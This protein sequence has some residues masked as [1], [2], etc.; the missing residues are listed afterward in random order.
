M[1]GP[2]GRRDDGRPF[3]RGGC[4]AGGRC[5]PAGAYAQVF[6]PAPRP[7]L[8]ARRVGTAALRVRSV[9]HSG[10]NP[11]ILRD[12]K[13]C[14]NSPDEAEMACGG[15]VIAGGKTPGVFQTVEAV[16]GVGVM[17]LVGDRHLWLGQ[18]GICQGVVAG[19][20]RDL[21]CTEGDSRAT[22]MGR[23]WPLAQGWIWSRSH[24]L[25]GRDPDCGSPL[26]PAAQWRARTIALSIICTLSGPASR[27]S[28]SLGTVSRTPAMRRWSG[29]R[30]P[31][32]RIAGGPVRET[33]IPP[34]TPASVPG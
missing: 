6:L 25:S 23:P 13:A 16:L 14:G 8:G 2:S 32:P 17:V 18:V 15:L 1:P 33:S 28:R 19:M 11:I 21:A 30:P 22:V 9:P 3:R 31:A 34:A 27:A 10:G 7:R 5:R 12:P 4:T 29:S 20:V 24:P 26:A